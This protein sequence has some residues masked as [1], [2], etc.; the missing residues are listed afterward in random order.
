V[1]AAGAKATVGYAAAQD[2]A[3]AAE[4]R[5]GEKIKNLK[6]SGLVVK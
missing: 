1:L 4:E 2:T 3:E 6:S 5:G